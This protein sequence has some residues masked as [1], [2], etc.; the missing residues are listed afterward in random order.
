MSSSVSYETLVQELYLAYFG[1][2]SDYFGLQNFEFALANAG[3][4]TDA[5]GLGAVY[6]SNSAVTTLVDSFGKSTESTTLYGG[7]STSDFV[8]AVFTD[9]FNRPAAAAGLL[10][11]TNAIDTHE[12]SSGQ[13][14]LSILE[15]ALQNS[16]QQG[17]VDQQTIAN[18]LA[19]SENFTLA[20]GSSSSTIV[21]YAG[22]TAAADARLML[23]QVNAT[24]NP[25]AVNVQ[26][27]IYDIVSP[28]ES[29]HTLTTSIGTVTG[30]VGNN[31]FSAVL[32]NPA[33]LAAGGQAQTLLSGDAI[34]GGSLN[35]TLNLTD[36]GL[37]SLMTI[38]SGVTFSGIGV[39]NISSLEGVSVDFSN[40][41]SLYTINLQHSTGSDAVVAGAIQTVDVSD[42]LGNVT[43]QGGTAVTVATDTSHAVS[44]SSSAA[45]Y[46][47]TVGDSTNSVTDLAAGASVYVTAGA[48]AN[49]VMLGAGATGAITFAA[50]T[51]ADTV[52][53]GPSEGNAKACVYITGLNNSGADT[54]SFSGDANTLAGFAEVTAAAVTASGGDTASL[55][56]W[57]RAADGA[58]GS[59][60][61]GAAHT[62][63]WFVF[64]GN[65]YLLESVAGQSVDA[66]TMASGNTLVELSGTGYT[67]GHTTG[68]GGTLHLLG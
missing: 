13:A 59:G 47:V 66:G 68:A 61:N 42:S 26:Q 54:I 11:W 30:G 48:G 57:I 18:K 7:G 45:I 3:A 1:R 8:N 9:L 50:H 44:L 21:A 24:T 15:G 32:D 12:V 5:V 51:A 22:P 56:A 2:P 34:V 43:V 49:T 62:V 4:P 63:N 10:F 60:V 41:Q 64:Q 19:V 17:L 35:N 40:W 25:D 36:F 55:A 39:V 27:V 52:V 67:F 14:A 28:L 65:T 20:L 6:K 58:Q 53:L 29:N 37:R 31:V 33:G 16:S 23:S 46:T 38:P